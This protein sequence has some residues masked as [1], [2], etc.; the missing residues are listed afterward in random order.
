MLPDPRKK[1]SKVGTRRLCPKLS[2]ARTRRT[3]V[4]NADAQYV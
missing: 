3:P 4:N 2:G 1:F